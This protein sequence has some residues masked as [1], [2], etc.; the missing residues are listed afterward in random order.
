MA[1]GD[2]LK[3]VAGGAKRTVTGERKKPDWIKNPPKGFMVG[4]GGSGEGNQSKAQHDVYRQLLDRYNEKNPVE[5]DDKG[6]ATRESSIYLPPFSESFYDENGQMYVLYDSSKAKVTPKG[7][8]DSSTKKGLED[9]V[10]GAMERPSEPVSEGTEEV[11][12]LDELE[13][14]FASEEDPGGDIGSAT[15]ADI[16]DLKPA[17]LKELVKEIAQEELEVAPTRESEQVAPPPTLAS[18]QVAPPPTLESE[19]VAAQPTLASEQVRGPD[20]K[21]G[22]SARLADPAELENLKRQMEARGPIRGTEGAVNGQ[23]SGGLATGDQAKQLQELGRGQMS[24]EGS[25]LQESIAQ[26]TGGGPAVEAG[27]FRSLPRDRVSEIIKEMNPNFSEQE[28]NDVVE[29]V[30]AGGAKFSTEGSQAIPPPAEQPI[31]SVNE[32]RM[33]T[34]RGGSLNPHSQS[35]LPEDHPLQNPAG[36]AGTRQAML[37]QE[38]ALRKEM[39]ANPLPSQASRPVNGFMGPEMGSP[40]HGL[41]QAMN[42]PEPTP[43]DQGAGYN[44]RMRGVYQSPP[45]GSAYSSPEAQQRAVPGLTA[46]ATPPQQQSFG[47]GGPLGSAVE[48]AF[49]PPAEQQQ[50]RMESPRADEMERKLKEAMGPMRNFNWNQQGQGGPSPRM[51]QQQGRMEQQQGINTLDLPQSKGYPGSDQ[52]R[53]ADL[54][55][56]AAEAAAKRRAEFSAKQGPD[57][58]SALQAQMAEGTAEG[59]SGEKRRASKGIMDRIKAFVDKGA[60]TPVAKYGMNPQNHTPAQKKEMEEWMEA[61]RPNEWPPKKGIGRRPKLTGSLK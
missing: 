2:F 45:G 13:S 35:P 59:P 21:G 18:E 15:L 36:N 34:A 6:E 31:A 33:G 29:K 27:G 57:Q 7:S 24:G 40:Q 17:Q 43:Q 42:I 54:E 8:K 32:E 28:L 30:I 23:Q 58:I 4:F 10:K 60:N 25:L 39:E 38:L 48:Q 56:M 11:V 51:E 49:T 5:Y 55:R 37:D 1:I 14:E 47:F 53:Q 61:G 46:P 12:S 20:P 52:G 41:P 50:G 16:E 26:R 9:Q 22:I 44:E 3:G 19:Q